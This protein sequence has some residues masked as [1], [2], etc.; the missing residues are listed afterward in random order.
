[1]VYEATDTTF[2]ELIQADYAAVDFYGTHCGPCKILE[3]VYNEMSN[4]YAMLRFVKVNVDHCPELKERFHI[5]AV[6]TLKYFRDG[7]L[8]YEGKTHGDR[9]AMDGEI[10]KLLYN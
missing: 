2:D 9:A 5:V 7:K 10:A 4:D 1:M 3:P 6:P 8:F